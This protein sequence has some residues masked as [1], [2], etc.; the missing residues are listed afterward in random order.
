MP[1]CYVNDD[2]YV[3][4]RLVLSYCV[5]TRVRYCFPG[6]LR[7]GFI[8]DGKSKKNSNVTVVTDLIVIEL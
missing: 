7:F 3:G 8:Q 2:V 6:V 5:A 1:Y 4:L